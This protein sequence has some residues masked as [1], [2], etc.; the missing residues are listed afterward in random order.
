MSLVFLFVGTIS[1]WAQNVPLSGLFT[2]NG[3][4]FSAVVGVL[5]LATPTTN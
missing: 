2:V 1:T 5:A 4:T 3:Q